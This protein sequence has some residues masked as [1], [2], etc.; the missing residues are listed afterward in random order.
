MTTRR[1]L[2]IALWLPTLAVGVALF[3]VF[4]WPTPYRYHEYR[5]DDPFYIP[6][7]TRVNRLTGRTYIRFDPN[8]PW[9]E[10]SRRGEQKP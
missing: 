7:K 4:V 9:Q 3:L 10:M 8:Q 1:P 5:E 6:L 2:P